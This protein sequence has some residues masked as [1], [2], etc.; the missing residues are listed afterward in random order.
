MSQRAIWR[1]WLPLLGSWLLLTL[2][3]PLIT[4]VINRLPEPVLMLAAQGIVLSLSVLIES[5]IINLLA[6]STAKVADQPT[7]RL[8]RRFALHWMVLLTAVSILV[9]WTPVFDWLVVRV[10]GVRSEIA[11]WVRVGLRIN[12]FWSAAIAWRRF[13]QGVLIKAGR[14]RTV[15]LGTLVRLF[16]GAA[17]AVSLAVWTD[18]PGVVIGAT[19]LFIGVLSEALYATAAARPAVRQLPATAELP[20]DYADLFWFHLPLAATS[21]L[22]LL[23]QP[24]AVYTLARLANADQTLAAWPVLFQ[25]L[26]IARA[27]AMAAP[28]AIIALMQR[29]GAAA[30]RRFALTLAVGV[31]TGMLV[32]VFTPLLDV[33]LDRVQ[34]VPAGVGDL[35]RHGVWLCLVF[36]VVT[37]AIF[38]LRGFLISRKQT[39]TVNGGMAVNLAAT[40]AVL[41]V[42][43]WQQWPGITTAALALNL[44]AVGELL[45][46]WRQFGRHLPLVAPSSAPA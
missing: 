24:L 41:A 3:G 6:T 45:F 17:V 40:A 44:A 11:E 10:M 1:F 37:L 28:E 2:E 15:A 43:L 4:T 18:L 30:L 36:P 26:L 9:A 32:L 7:Y 12:I 31:L 22:A 27:P 46:L 16:S 14:T 8:V 19:T 34:R 21:V 20:L 13:L 5:P 25:I 33:W 39:G 35:V 23:V 42:G 38:S 29:A